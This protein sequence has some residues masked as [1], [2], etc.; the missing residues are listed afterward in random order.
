MDRRE[1]S[2]SHLVGKWRGQFIKVKNGKGLHDDLED[3]LKYRKEKG[4]AFDQEQVIRL[5]RRM[6]Y[7]TSPMYLGDIAE[8]RCL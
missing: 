1:K 7:K 6:A 5:P 8:G 2:R 4:E 3:L